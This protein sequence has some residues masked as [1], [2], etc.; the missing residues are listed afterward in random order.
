MGVNVDPFRGMVVGGRYRILER[1]GRGGM[2][3]VYRVEHLALGKHLAMKLLSGDL[4]RV[5]GVLRRFEQEALTASRLSHPNTV[6]VVDRGTTDGLTW[7][8]MELVQGQDLSRV[9]RSE[10]PM[11]P[12]RVVRLLVQV[13]GSLSEAHKQGIVHRD[14]K[15]ANLM[16]TCS[17]EGEEAVKVLDFG[18]AKLRQGPE[19]N[20]ITGR[21]TVLGT[22]AYMAPEQI[23][24]RPVDGRADIY[25]LGGVAY[26]LLTGKHV[27]GGHH[28]TE[29][30]MARHLVEPPVPP[31]QR[32]P[33]LGIPEAL[34]AVVVKALAKRP[35]DRFASV[36]ELR[37]A[38]LQ[39]ITEDEV[40]LDEPESPASRP[41]PL[42]HPG[43][44][45]RDEVASYERKLVRQ[46]QAVRGLVAA[47]LMAAASVVL[48]AG[49]VLVGSLRS[50][51]PAPEEYAS[52]GAVRRD[53]RCERP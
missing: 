8:V 35:E 49:W 43:P 21:G 14:I 13:C 27:F 31:Q 25:A 2:G 9:L 20:E 38:L 16:L 7:L 40:T 1:L 50:G 47:G 24:G 45:L 48:G 23:E 5:P 3:L 17:A 26:R 34:G 39:S 10:G 30:L 12:V 33:H 29:E 42:V 28:S 37:R 19:L 32:A 52:H 18:L 15:P 53:G 44:T 6:Q 46:R 51:D 36:E 4:A 22:P 41:I 11:S